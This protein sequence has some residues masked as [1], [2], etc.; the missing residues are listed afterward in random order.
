MKLATIARLL[1][2]GDDNCD[3]ED[4]DD[5][6]NDDDDDDGEIAKLVLCRQLA[7][8]EEEGSAFK[9]TEDIDPYFVIQTIIMV[10][11]IIIL[12]MII[13]IQVTIMVRMRIIMVVFMIIIIGH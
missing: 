8:Y 2:V 9:V 10:R 1:M 4:D 12:I 11:I 7:S 5:D 13:V 3:I 6:A